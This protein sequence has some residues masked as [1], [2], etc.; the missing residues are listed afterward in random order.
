MGDGYLVKSNPIYRLLRNRALKAGFRY[1]RDPAPDYFALPLSQLEHFLEKKTIPYFD[2]VNV[3]EELEKKAPL[4]TVWDDV[5]DNL[6]QNHVFHETAHAVARAAGIAIFESPLSP[7][8]QIVRLLIEE[9]FAN[10]C[11]LLGIVSVEDPAHRIFYEINSYSSMYDERTLLKNLVTDV[12]QKSA[13]E[14]LI[15][16]YL[17]SNFLHE[18]FEDSSFSEILN[19]VGID[20]KK[21]LRPAGKIAFKLNPRFRLV[22]TVF[23]LRISGFKCTTQEINAIDFI[24]IIKQAAPYRRFISG[25]GDAVTSE[26]I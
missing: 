8:Q 5:T 16:S 11:E 10:A 22:T 18:R 2:N 21:S 19:L 20:P 24:S 13:I 14:F 7:P 4:A 1:S 3:L 9:S 23:Y 25:L 6:R 12:G 17:F 26:L 15:Y